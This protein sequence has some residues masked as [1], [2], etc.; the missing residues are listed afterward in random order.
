[1][2]KYTKIVD[3]TSDELG[4]TRTA[5]LVAA[6]ENNYYLHTE[7]TYIGGVYTVSAYPKSEWR[8]SKV[9]PERRIEK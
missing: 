9:Y 1:M 4:I 6:D 8:I 3:L 2:E 7:N 5:R